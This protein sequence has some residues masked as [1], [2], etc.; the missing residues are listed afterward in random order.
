[1]ATNALM[2]VLPTFYHFCSQRW[3]QI[4]SNVLLKPRFTRSFPNL[5]QNENGLTWQDLTAR[6]EMKCRVS[7]EH[8]TCSTL[9]WARI[10]WE[11]GSW[12]PPSPKTTCSYP[13]VLPILKYR[14]HVLPLILILF[15]SFVMFTRIFYAVSFTDFLAHPHG[16][17]PPFLLQCISSNIGIAFPYQELVS[18]V[19]LH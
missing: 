8:F 5:S 7:Q 1:M 4:L 9:S 14:I 6:H 2:Y 12:L 17:V 13:V 15:L 10:A 16:I 3:P 18:W 11:S 19:W